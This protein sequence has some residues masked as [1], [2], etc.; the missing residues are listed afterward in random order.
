MKCRVRFHVFPLFF[1]LLI[2]FLA[3]LPLL[4]QLPT[5]T[6]NGTVTDPTGATVAGARV[7]AA[8]K[9][10]GISREAT[11]GA[12]GLYVVTNLAP[13]TYDVRVEAKGFAVK[14]F[15]DVRLEVGRS[16]TLD[17]QLALAALGQKVEI[18][19]G[20][21]Q[22]E[23]TQSTVQ[24]Q[25]TATTV[26]NIP[27][28]GRNYLELAS[29]VP[30]NRPA[31]NF[32]PTKTNTLE[33]SSAG[34]FGRGGNL[35][36]DGGSN[37]DAVVG[38][39]LLNFPQDSI[40]EFQIATNRFTAEVGRS[41][42]SII[43]IAT[44]SGTNDYHGSLFVFVRNKNLQARSAVEDRTKPQPRFD[45]QHFGGS[46]GGPIF[47]DRAWWFISGED[48]NQHAAVQV[49]ER[50]FAT[51]Q[52]PV[53]TSAR[54]PLDDLV[55]PLLRLDYKITDKDNFYVRYSYNRSIEVDNGSLRRPLG[56]A[57]NR[58]SSLNRFNSFFGSWARTFNP[59]V[60]NTLTFNMNTFVNDIPAFLNNH[61]TLVT[62]GPYSGGVINTSLTN[63]LRFPSLQDG[64]NFRIPQRTRFNSY[65]VSDDV[66]WTRSKHAFHFGGRIEKQIVDALF[67]LFGSRTIVLSQDF[68]TADLD[69]DGVI[70][71]LD[72]PVAAAVVSTAPVRPPTYPP[73]SN[74]NFG[75]YIQDDWRVLPNLTLNLGVR[76]DVDTNVF[77][78]NEPFIPCPLPLNVQPTRRCV[79]AKTQLGLT[80]NRDLTN[81]GPRVGFAWDPFKKGTTVIRGGY[82]IY[83]DPIV[84]EVDLLEG[85]LDGRILSLQQRGGST[86]VAGRFV[87]D[88]MTGQIVSLGNNPFGG[89]PSS[90]P[91]GVN[92]IDPDAEH[93]R[94]QQFSLGVQ[95]QFG[96]LW[97]VSADGIHD[98]GDH[99]L[100]GRDLVGPGGNF[101]NVTDPLTGLTN[102][103]VNNQPAAK[104]WYDGLLVSVQKRPSRMRFFGR[105]LEKWT[106]TFNASY[107]LSKSLNYAND[108]QIPFNVN[109]P[110]DLAFGINQ[111]RLE[112]G[113][114]PT[115]ERHR[116][117]LYGVANGPYDIS[118]SPILTLSSSVPQDSL[119]S[120]LGIRLPILARDGIGRSVHNGREL[121]A[122]IQQWNALPP[123]PASGGVFPCNMGGPL[124]LVNP[125]LT[126][127]DKFASLD[128][129]VTKRFTFY[130][131]HK[132]DAIV[133]AFNIFN[134]TNIRGKNNNNFSGRANDITS[135][136]FYQ[137]KTTA[138]GFFGAGG[139]RAFQFALRYSF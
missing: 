122:V 133:E 124:P 44:K 127:G 107:T 113:Y 42:S 118:I 23:L 43:N 4:G 40:Q 126:F 37:V 26:E 35:T 48:R 131:R 12:D 125:N 129:R 136:S 95:H 120:A 47:K 55:G 119:V 72:L 63:E 29:L 6:L 3:N 121:N 139:P 67:D 36:V 76:W 7:V 79:W 17:A 110:V 77:G 100:L 90:V 69:G 87:P 27:L 82:G 74:V 28:N 132:V 56:S 97:V 101:V 65:Q 78:N 9:A 104:T 91:L 31:T 93:P 137:A 46:F 60:V 73:Y 8:N 1:L 135:R 111:A 68:A 34:Q 84:L 130:E 88:P 10:T 54:A 112:K 106:Y 50:N 30:G 105:E 39:T 117:S 61:P 86:I 109:S 20:A 99:F 14:E 64:A 116:L 103:V 138:G 53:T 13:G 71:D 134:V 96:Q 15:K 19:G 114:A 57:A 70:N 80:A 11:S 18:S 51:L 85:L 102:I 32:D 108:D 89:A 123:C 21:T 2:F 94:V 83:Y 66:T 33:V 81:V 92:I 115:D 128:F 52:P 98:F 16:V 38:G 62:S 5:A 41:G 75:V 24:G 22:V 59:R 49:G 45:R 58:Q 25:I